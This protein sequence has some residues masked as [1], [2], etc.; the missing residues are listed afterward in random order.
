MKKTVIYDLQQTNIE[1]QNKLNKQKQ[2]I[3]LLKQKN[4]NTKKNLVNML[5][6]ISNIGHSDDKYKV[7]HML[8]IIDKNIKEISK[9][10]NVDLLN[11]NEEKIIK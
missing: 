11:K 5:I 6:E 2:I 10:L 8:D 7:I 3:E 9:D 1:Q 4:I